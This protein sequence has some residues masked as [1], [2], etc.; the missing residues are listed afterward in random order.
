LRALA[1]RGVQAQGLIP[2][3]PSKTFPNH[4]TVVTGLYPGHHGIV[5]NTIYDPGADAWF[6]MSDVSAVTNGR[7]WGG[8]PLWVT[9]EKQGQHAATMFWPGSEAEID[10][11]RPSHTRKYDGRVSNRDRVRQVLEWLDLTGEQHPTFLTLYMSDVDGAGHRYGPDSPQVDSAIATVDSAIGLLVE[12]LRERGVLDRTDII[13]VSDHGMAATSADRVVILD[14]YINPGTVTVIDWSPVLAIRPRP[15]FEDSV[16]RGLGRAAH[17][18]VWRKTELP[19]RFH[20]LD[21][22]RVAPIIGLA[23]EGWS[24]ATRKRATE[25]PESFNGGNHGFDPAL[26]SMHGI[27]IAAGPDFSQGTTT[28]PVANVHLYDLMAHVLGLTPAKN[29]GSLDSV[30]AVLKQ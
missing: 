11:V 29:D 26:P 6:R 7:W 8:E 4:Y 18:R 30:R 28:P 15:G 17:M 5:A 3:F 13:I 14:D 20:Y 21:S 9:A 27:F 24:I 25:S 19:E 10:G 12:G 16:Y 1:A 22:P 23:D 2:S